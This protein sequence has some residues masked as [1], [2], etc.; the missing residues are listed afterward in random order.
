MA[1]PSR[2]L[3]LIPLVAA[4]YF[5]VSGGPYGLEELIQDTGYGMSVLLLILIPLIWSLPTSLMVGEL[6]AAIPAEGGFYVWVTRALGPFWGFQEAWLSLAASIFDM[7]S[8]PAVFVLYLGRVWPAATAGYNGILIGAAVVGACVVWNLAGAR[9]VGDGSVLLGILLLSPFAAIVVFALIHHPELG[10]TP[11]GFPVHGGLLAGI[12]VAMWNYM[13]WDNASTIAADVH[14]PHHNY[15]RA[16][17]GAVGIVALSY[18]LPVV[19]AWYAG[20]PAAGFDTGSWADLAGTLGGRW[21]RAFTAM[22]AMLSAFGMFNALVLSYSRLPL[23][24]A[25]DGML[26]R[27]FARVHRRTGA[28]WVSIVVLA[29]AWGACLRL[30]F[31]RLVALDIMLYG[32]S[33]ALEFAALVALRLR[34]PD[35]PRAFSVPGGVRGTIAVAVPPMALL[36]FSLLQSGRD[37]LLGAKALLLASGIVAGGFLLYALGGPARSRFRKLRLIQDSGAAISGEALG[38][39]E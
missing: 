28:P 13:G 33:L 39:N 29:L 21:L 15:P 37:H 12:M 27:A 8:Y 36:V 38:E 18:V 25:Q 35:L 5:M 26:P 23:A 6:S 2:K 31:E 14:R 32:I 34:A 3:T 16:M 1:R 20:T 10:N 4:T 24:M 30:G 17:L 22:A 19:A 9:A 7:A 11:S